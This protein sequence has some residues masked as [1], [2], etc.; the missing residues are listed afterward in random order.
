MH[1]SK[2]QAWVRFLALPGTPDQLFDRYLPLLGP[3]GVA[4]PGSILAAIELLLTLVIDRTRFI[5][6]LAEICYSLWAKLLVLI[7]DRDLSV[8]VSASR[9]AISLFQFTKPHFQNEHHVEWLEGLVLASEPPSLV[10]VTILNFVIQ[11]RFSGFKYQTLV[12]LMIAQGLNEL[13]D[14]MIFKRLL[15]LPQID[16]PLPAI[17]F[18]FAKAFN[19]PI[20]GR[21]AADILREPLARFADLQ[22]IVT[23]MTVFLRRTFIFVGVSAMLNRYHGKRMRILSLFESLQDCRIEWI[24]RTVIRYYSSLV[25]SE[26]LRHNIVGF[27]L[28]RIIDHSFINQVDDMIRQPISIKG[29]FDYTNLDGEVCCSPLP[30]RPTTRQ[31]RPSQSKP[32]LVKRPKSDVKHAKS[33]RLAVPKSRPAPSPI[34]RSRS[35]G[36]SKSKAI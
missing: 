14:F 9:A 18:L 28:D 22:V 33:P 5:S 1:R 29:F 10:H 35:L 31:I 17:Q 21:S 32:T 30:P 12:R 2:T 24:N 20:F 36:F 23:W 7:R 6:R 4:P 16:K 13:A 25:N 8:V 27:G 15:L 3:S 26:R 11:L 19:D 34:C